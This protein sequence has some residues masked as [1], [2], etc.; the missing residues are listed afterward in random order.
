MRKRLL[1]AV[2]GVVLVATPA[3]VATAAPQ[4]TGPTG[5]A[6]SGINA[7][8]TRADRQELRR[9]AADTWASFEAMT[10]ETTGLPADNIEGDLDPATRSGYTSPTNIGAYLWSTVAARDIGLISRTEARHRMAQTL[11]TLAGMERHEPSG[12]FYNWY[13]EATGAKLVE[14]PGSGEVIH[15]FVSTVDNGWFAAALMVV[16]SAEPRL[17]AQAQ[18][19][20]DGMN[21]AFFHNPDARGGDLPGWNR[22]GFWVD[23]PPA[24]QCNVP[25][26]YGDPAGAPLYYTCHHYDL[27]NSETRIAVYVGIALGQIPQEAYYSLWR[28]FPDTCD[29]DWAEQQPIGT[30]RSYLGI[31]VYEGTFAYEDL[32]MVP[33]WGGSMFEELMPDLFVPEQRWAPDSW[34]ANHPLAVQAHIRHGL[35]EADYGYWGFSPASNPFGGYNAYGVDVI[36]M[37]SDGYFSD[38]EGTDVDGGF[39]DCREGANPEPEFGDGVVTPHAAFLAIPYAPREAVDNLAGIEDELGAYGPGGFFDSVAVSGT[40]AERYLSLDQGMILGA[41]G[42][43]LGHDALHR[44]FA[45][46]EV[47]QVIRPLIG[48]EEFSSGVF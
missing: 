13:D 34:G 16:R 24:E 35:D 4:P 30:T 21:F 18:D 25:G 31:D 7:D 29:W 11:D 26:N 32:H 9:W 45:R 46:G 1:A 17:R 44:Y 20:L 2:T 15:P 22:G 42:N 33:T 37:Q 19:L 14:F 28:T 40:A 38:I 3:A 36:G 27:L 12:M 41:L 48:M 23:E 10:D 47:A 5:P 8:L 39:G 6:P 43:V